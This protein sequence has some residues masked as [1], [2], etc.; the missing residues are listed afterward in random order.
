MNKNKNNLIKKLSL[1][2]MLLLIITGCRDDSE[3]TFNKLVSPISL[4]SPSGGSGP[5]AQFIEF[6][7]PNLIGLISIDRLEQ[8]E[9]IFND[10]GDYIHFQNVRGDL[11][12]Y[13]VNHSRST[14][15]SLNQKFY[16]YD[17][18]NLRK[19]KI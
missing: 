10:V 2:A 3:Q 7:K 5:Y 17:K 14:L 6:D 19:G 4:F 16:Q 12:G 15:V 18:I 9:F 11:D 1:L 8:D 13:F